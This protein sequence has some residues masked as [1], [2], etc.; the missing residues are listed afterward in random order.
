MIIWG[1]W[2]STGGMIFCSFLFGMSHASYGPVQSEIT[3]L[4]VGV[5]LYSFAF[6]SSWLSMA[7]GWALGAPVAGNVPPP[8][9][10]KMPCNTTTVKNV[11][12]PTAL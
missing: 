6:S 10:V 2:T 3:I 1:F 11:L 5:E 8:N 12:T 9:D 7:V 4:V